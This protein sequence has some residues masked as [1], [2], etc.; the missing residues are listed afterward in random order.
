MTKKIL[1][2]CVM[3]ICISGISTYAQQF[4]LFTENFES[5][6]SLFS[7]NSGG[8]STGTGSNKWII[9]NSYTGTPVYDNT[10]S[11]D[12]TVSGTIGS[13]PNSSYL[14]IHDE[15]TRLGGGVSNANYNG[16]VPSDQFAFI[17]SGFCTLGMSD[18]IFT[19]F[20]LGEGDPNAYG[21]VY[22]SINNGPWIN[23]GTRF[24]N[25]R[26]WKY[27]VLTHP[28]WADKQDV[29]IGFRWQNAAGS[30]TRVSSWGLDD[31]V[32]VGTYDTTRHAVRMSVPSVFPNPVCQLSYL[33]INWNLTTK[34]K[35]PAAR[36]SI[37]CLIYQNCLAQRKFQEKFWILVV[38]TGRWRVP[39]QKRVLMFGAVNGIVT[40]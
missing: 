2:F 36:R 27:E 22:Y 19:F 1:L 38:E 3:L 15:A 30:S 24:S 21:E 14:H 31:F 17:S 37:S 10:L 34:T 9:N 23:Y 18:I 7:L 33:F 32:A 8:P 16:T 6:F 4:I 26:R 11:Q 39:W 13:A 29:R 28:D 5:G 12:S 25:Q 20:W 40:G 35:L